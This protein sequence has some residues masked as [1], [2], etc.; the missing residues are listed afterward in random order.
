MAKVVKVAVAEETVHKVTQQTVQQILAEAEVV[1]VMVLLL[2][3]VTA[4]LV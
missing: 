1:T 4:V 3:Q 2:V